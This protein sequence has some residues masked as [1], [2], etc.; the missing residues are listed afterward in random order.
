MKARAQCPFPKE[1][2]PPQDAT[3]VALTGRLLLSQQARVLNAEN[4][5]YPTGFVNTAV[6]TTAVRLQS[7]LKI[8]ALKGTELE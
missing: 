7:P 4:Q 1:G 5:G 8:S 6:F 2:I 3:K